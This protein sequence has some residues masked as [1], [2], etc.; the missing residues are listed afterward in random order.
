MRP[1]PEALIARIAAGAAMLCH[2]WIKFGIEAP[3]GPLGHLPQR[4]RIYA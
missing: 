2:A 1:I 3:S 4:G